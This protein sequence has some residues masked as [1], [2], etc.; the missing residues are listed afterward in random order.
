MQVKQN[1]CVAMSG[2]V[3]KRPP[4]AVV[5]SAAAGA[6]LSI[7]RDGLQMRFAALPLRTGCA[8]AAFCS[9]A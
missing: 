6:V 4:I 8:A 1:N 2:D 7:G 9:P 3:S 5:P